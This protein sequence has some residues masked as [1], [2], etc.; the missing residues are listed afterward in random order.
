MIKLNRNYLLTIMI[1]NNKTHDLLGTIYFEVLFDVS[2]SRFEQIFTFSLT[3]LLNI[4][5]NKFNQFY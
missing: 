4:I 5:F 1:I 2:V 3:I